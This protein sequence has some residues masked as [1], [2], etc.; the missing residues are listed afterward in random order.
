MD[1]IG[2][3]YLPNSALTYNERG[4][5]QVDIVSKDDKRAYTLCVASTPDGDFLP[6]QQVFS[7][8]SDKSLPTGASI[9]MDRAR[10]YGFHF[11]YAK[12]E[13]ASSHYSTLKTMKEVRNCFHIK[14]NLY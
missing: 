7:G 10:E 1:Q 14:D 8:A 5:K 4:A 2:V 3:Y 9:G 6:F 11:A 13:K 12:S